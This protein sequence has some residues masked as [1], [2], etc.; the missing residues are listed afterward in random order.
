MTWVILQ[1]NS[2]KNLQE[3]RVDAT[4]GVNMQTWVQRLRLGVYHGFRYY[5]RGVPPFIKVISN[6]E[7]VVGGG[8]VGRIEGGG[9]E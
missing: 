2:T 4:P 7:P 8:G 3:T 9:E 1:S 6:R 5:S